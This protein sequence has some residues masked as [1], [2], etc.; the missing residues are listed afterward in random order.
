MLAPAFGSLVQLYAL[1]LDDKAGV[2]PHFL[3]WVNL[4]LPFSRLMIIF[5][6]LIAIAKFPRLSYLK[7]MSTGEN[8]FGDNLSENLILIRFS[9]HLLSKIVPEV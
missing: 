3:R 4:N 2:L 6:D 9:D 8:V 1:Q 5:F 7:A